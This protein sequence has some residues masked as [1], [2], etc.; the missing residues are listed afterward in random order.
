MTDDENKAMALLLAA[1]RNTKDA[2]H[3]LDANPKDPAARAVVRAI[4][5]VDLALKALRE[6]IENATV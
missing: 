3:A 6:R 2:S 1:K 4:D 5:A